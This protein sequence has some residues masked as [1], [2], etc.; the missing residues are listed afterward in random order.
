MRGIL[1]LLALV[2]AVAAAQN[3]PSVTYQG[4][5]TIT[6]GGTYTGNYRSTSSATPAV[7][8]ATTAPVTLLNCVLVGPGDLI[9]ANGA[10]ADL[11]VLHCRAYGTTPT[12]D[13][14][15]RGRFVAATNARNIRAEHNYLEHTTGFTIY[16]FSGDGSANQT[17]R[18]LR[19]RVR[20]VDGRTRNG[21]TQIA[22][23]VGLNTVRNLANI[24][25]AWN[26]VINEPNLSSVEDN[27]NLYNSG[28][29]AQSPAKVHDNYVQG[30]YP[31]PATAATFTG[32]GMTT[33]GG[34]VGSASETAAFINAYN[35]Q[36]VSTCNAGM[37][38]AAG[39]DISYYNNR[40]V[41]SA[42]LPDGTPL[43]AVYA[44]TSVF[45]GNRAP[46]SIFFNN[47]IRNNTIGYRNPAYSIPYPGR[48]D[49]SNGACATCTGTVHL[50]NPITL[51]TEQ[52]ELTLW[53]QKLAQNGIVIGP[54]GTSSP[55][56]PAN[57]APVVQL[58]A[59]ATA[60][61]GTALALTATASDA[62]GTVA[63]V[64][65]F[66]GATK[67]G[68]DTTAPYAFSFAPAAAGTLSLTAR[69]TDNAGAATTS[70]PVAVT[71]AA[72]T[73]SPTPAPTTGTFYRALNL[74][75][76]ALTIDGRAWE[77]A[78]GASGFTTN[79]PSWSSPTGALSPA[80]D[81]ARATMLRTVLFG[82]GP[83]LALAVPSGSYNVYLYIWEDNAPAIV[84]IQVEG[85]TVRTGYSTGSA[86]HWERLGPYAA[87]VTDGTLNVSTSGENVNL[88]GLEIYKATSTT[89]NTA[90]VVQLSA[91]A[92]A[93]AGT[94]LAL[95]ATAS[96][97]NGTVARVE[98]FS[99]AT[100]LGEDTTA[101]YAFSF[102][103]AAAGTLSLTARATDNAGAATTSAPV[104]VTVAATTTGT[105]NLVLNGGFESGA[106]SP[107]LTWLNGGKAGLS[108]T[109]TRA[110]TYTAWA[111]GGVAYLY[112]TVKGLRPNTTY[113]LTCDVSAQ[114]TSGASAWV[115]V[116]NAG[117]SERHQEVGNTSGGWRAVSQTFTTGSTATT[118]E[119]Y[120][121][122]G[123]AT[124]TAWIDQVRVAPASSTQM[125]SA[126]L[127]EPRSTAEAGAALSVYPNPVGASTQLHLPVATAEIV[128]LGI[129]TAQGK[130]ISLQRVA[131]APQGPD[132]TV[133]TAALP[134]GSYVLR[135]LS[136]SLRGQSL[137]FGK[138]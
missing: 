2:P 64:E 20:N 33:D 128:E 67:L 40:I 77:A 6:Q 133:N 35:N 113:T 54:N 97:A 70:A 48:H 75:G 39:H 52:N 21:G 81:A 125:Q 47:T 66:S 135:V 120:L 89:A 101:P 129:Y 92:T 51:A 49:L 118:A 99:G 136:G 91:P 55:T 93:T 87:N 78:A 8:I 76:P 131:A 58:S 4:P 94:A 84:N 41:T 23:F 13:N 138:E 45:N 105:T 1:A 43:R 69:A 17:V 83:T 56:T 60:T 15:Y 122:I 98:F 28:G 27:I 124:T 19:N 12:Q 32:T 9:Q 73:T 50:P 3:V 16:R 126:Q 108:K 72:T 86:G 62:N 18:I 57:T 103:P 121:W 29:T 5:I 22:N 115:G 100:K 30:A 34:A 85:R 137:H 68:E 24:E 104:A 119:V 123:E 71:V 11:S 95:T 59:P 79:A 44:A 26:Q 46:S 90:P 127:A 116:K 65:F 102:A 114:S 111:G 63:R 107:W 106:L 10:V 36:F 31:F 96:D 132:A 110:G 25:I 42:L 109:V 7:T 134:A 117:T 38:I 61:V 14:R 53:Q 37:N 82:T 88:S 80:T 112:Q 130:T 74:G